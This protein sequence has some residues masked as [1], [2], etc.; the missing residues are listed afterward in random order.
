MEPH[1][2]RHSCVTPACVF[3][4]YARSG[5]EATGTCR[6]ELRNH[7]RGGRQARSVRATW[8]KQRTP[9]SRSST[10]TRSSAECTRRAASW[11]S[12]V[13]IG[14]KPYATVPN[15]SR[16]QWLSVNPATAAARPS[17]RAHPRRRS[18]D[19][20]PERRLERRAR[21]A[22][23]VESTRT[24]SPPR[25]EPT[26]M[27][28]S[29]S[30]CVWSGSRRQSTSTSQSEGITFRRSEAEIIVGES[31][32]DSS[33]STSSAANGSSVARQLQHLAGFRRLPPTTAC[34]KRLGLGPQLRLG[35]IRGEPLDQRA[36]PWPA[37]CPRCPASRRGP[38]G[39]AP[40]GGTASSSSRRSSRGRRRARRARRARPS[41]R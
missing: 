37:R 39:R 8:R 7:G 27:I 17:R 4:R 2:F 12:I 13:R 28:G 15:A 38:R 33:G 31:V 30:A 10:A 32:S 1:H 5:E 26:R 16:S 21:P 20:V 35:A 18:L 34:T 22:T 40:S 19:R 11:G 3:P 24:R 41:P 9:S 14:K 36:P 23:A 25:R 6:P 29:A